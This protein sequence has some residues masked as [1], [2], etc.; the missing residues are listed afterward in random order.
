MSWRWHGESYR[1]G[2][3]FAPFVLSRRFGTDFHARISP[4]APVPHLGS[5]PAALR[6]P[7]S[8]AMAAHKPVEWVQAVITRFDEQVRWVDPRDGCSD[9]RPGLGPGSPVTPPR[10]RSVQTRRGTAG[11]SR[12]GEL[13][14]RDVLAISVPAAQH[15][16]SG[17]LA[18]IHHQLAAPFPTFLPVFMRKPAA[19]TRKTSR[20]P[21]RRSFPPLFF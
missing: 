10:F 7:P 5:A 1:K 21:T 13:P 20:D 11:F 4:P 17:S 12:G 16:R 6:R 15:W 14:D 2:K 3:I 8:R 9:P 18:S 19:Q